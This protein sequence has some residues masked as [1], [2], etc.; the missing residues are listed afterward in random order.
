MDR[1]TGKGGFG[2]DDGTSNKVMRDV[3]S[4]L[5]SFQEG[6]ALVY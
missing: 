4:I 1:L 6:G 3:G 5:I 2:L